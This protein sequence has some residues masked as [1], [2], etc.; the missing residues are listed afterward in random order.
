MESSFIS[1]IFYKL[2]IARFKCYAVLE[3]KMQTMEEN[4]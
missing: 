1:N 2:Y 4:D 3:F